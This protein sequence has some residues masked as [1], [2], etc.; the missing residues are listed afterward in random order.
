M[1]ARFLARYETPADPASTAGIGVYAAADKD[2]S[3]G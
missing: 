2:E 1:T 3:G